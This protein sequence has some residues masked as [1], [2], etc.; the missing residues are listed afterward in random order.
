MTALIETLHLGSLVAAQAVSDMSFWGLFQQAGLVVKSVMVLLLILSIISWA[1]AVDKFITFRLLKSR[2]TKFEDTFW[3]GRTLDDLAS[4]LANDVRDPMARVFHAAM[5]EYKTFQATPRTSLSKD[6]K[7]KAESRINDIMDIV[8]NRELDKTEKGMG[9]LATIASISVFIGLFGTVWGI[10]NAF[11]GIAETQSTNLAVVAPGIA[12]ALFATALGLI[13]AIPAA[14]F[15]NMF[16][17]EINRYSS[18][19]EGYADE[20]SLNLSKKIWREG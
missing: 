9:V 16:T 2:A 19:L 17:T 18:R 6:A 5:E 13:A 8:I 15:S 20:L 4:G 7:E 3:S 14:V 11:Q 12:E 1:V 10:M